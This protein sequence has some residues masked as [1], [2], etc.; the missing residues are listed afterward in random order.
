MR[1]TM[2]IV[3]KRTRKMIDE[4]ESVV[5]RKR[6]ICVCSLNDK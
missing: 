1:K 6:S 4:A 5:Q 2:N 3:V